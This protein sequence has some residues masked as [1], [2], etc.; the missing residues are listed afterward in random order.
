MYDW[1]L[2]LSCNNFRI[3]SVNLY[4]TSANVP[5]VIKYFNG[6]IIL[7]RMNDVLQQKYNMQT[8]VEVLSINVG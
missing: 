7:E 3:L 8:T 5:H 1:S 2:S 6:Y 4:L